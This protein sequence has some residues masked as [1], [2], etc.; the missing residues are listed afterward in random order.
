[1]QGIESHQFDRLDKVFADYLQ[2]KFPDDEKLANQLIERA[3]RYFQSEN[4]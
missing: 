2:S 4:P 1:V 3:N